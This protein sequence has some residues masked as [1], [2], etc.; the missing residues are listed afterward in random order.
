MRNCCSLI[1]FTFYLSC[2]TCIIFSDLVLFFLADAG[3]STPARLDEVQ[4]MGAKLK[5]QLEV[6]RDDLGDALPTPI[7]SAI[8]A[9][10]LQASDIIDHVQSL[11]SGW[12]FLVIARLGV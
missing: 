11:L 12:C 7:P 4:K 8:A 6:F 1:F 3:W 10:T 9:V 2:Y 5:R